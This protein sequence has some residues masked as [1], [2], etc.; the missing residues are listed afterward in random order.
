MKVILPWVEEFATVP[1]KIEQ[2]MEKRA[3]E[4]WYA[5]HSKRN[6]PQQTNAT[7]SFLRSEKFRLRR[8]ITQLSDIERIVIYLRFWENLLVADIAMVMGFSERK[9]ES[10]IEGAVRELRALYIN[11]LN[12]VQALAECA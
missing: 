5:N 1:K 8:F 9:I 7:Y 4:N 12:R 11:E 2:L 3:L 10:I 6:R